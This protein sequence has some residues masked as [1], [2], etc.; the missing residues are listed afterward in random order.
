MTD[1]AIPE[2][3]RRF[4]LTSAPSVPYLEAMLLLRRDTREPWDSARLAQRLYVSGKIAEQLLVDLCA[5][6]LLVITDQDPPRYC[7]QPVSE[8]LRQMIDRVAVVYARNMVEVTHLI[9]STTSK[10]AQQ[11]ADAFK[12]RKDP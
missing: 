1:E 8:E 5:A 2:H 9:H 12:L 7:Y 6:G 11:F 4:I 3:V 10:K